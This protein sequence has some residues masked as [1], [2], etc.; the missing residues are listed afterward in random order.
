MVVVVVVLLVCQLVVDGEAEEV[1]KVP[2][3]TA[4]VLVLPDL[5]LPAARLRPLGEVAVSMSRVCPRTWPLYFETASLEVVAVVA[6]PFLLNPPSLFV[7]AWLVAVA[8]FQVLRPGLLDEGTSVKETFGQTLLRLLRPNQKSREAANRV[9]CGH[10]QR[11]GVR[12]MVHLSYISLVLTS[13]PVFL[14]KDCQNSP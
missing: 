11:A 14:C 10:R 3:L 1:E 6:Y 13:R 7:A 12:K 5:C 9:D 4:V 8:T 2:K